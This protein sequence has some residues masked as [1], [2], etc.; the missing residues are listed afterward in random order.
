MDGI[1]FSLADKKE[2]EGRGCNLL[3]NN[4]YKIT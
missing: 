1:F 4:E 2:R 3:M